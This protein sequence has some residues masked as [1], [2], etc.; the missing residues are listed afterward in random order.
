[1]KNFWICFFLL[2]APYAVSAQNS[3]TK[4]TVSRWPGGREAAV[5]LTFD[6]GIDSDLDHVGPILKKHHLHGTFFVNT[7]REPW[8]QRKAQWKRLAEEGNEIGN[9]TVNHPCLLT[10]ITP[11]S[12]DYTP[13]RMESE[14]RDAANDITQFL[15]LRRGLTFAY[16][17]G[18]MSFGK[19]GDEAKNSAL[20][21]DYVAKYHFGARSVGAGGPEDPDQLNVLDIGTLPST[22][23]K[24][25]LA[26]VDMAE[27]AI[28]QN[29]WG[30]YCF[31]GVGG[32]WL[33]ITPEALDELAGYLEKHAEIWTA[34][35]GDVL[36]YTQERRA[37]V[38]QASGNSA[39][40]VDLSL[41]WPMN[42]QIYDLPL[43]LKVEVP[44]AWTAPTATG[45][46]K[47]LSPRVLSQKNES[48]ILV[49]VP[50]QTARVR[51]AAGR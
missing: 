42:P 6:D 4:V 30:T 3:G 34:T 20:F 28:R 7:G 2:C 5:S 41:Q 29:G 22:A 44:A 36:R 19:P 1:M 16:P 10:E 21:M 39:D 13:E 43:T 37:A 18:N 27:P 45:D 11:H 31:H 49:D 15:N 8:K 38:V 25:F 24:D 23:G 17:C 12:Q 14:I 26:L 51:I 40:S 50:P 33:A 47:P 48:V 32:D 46:G 9:H 35:F